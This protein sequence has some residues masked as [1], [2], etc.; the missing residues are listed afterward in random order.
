MKNTIETG[1]SVVAFRQK[2][3]RAAD[4]VAQGTDRKAIIDACAETLVAMKTMVNER[5]ITLDAIW[6]HYGTL[7]VRA[8][9]R[10][11]TL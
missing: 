9:S 10:E 3:G 6:K 7:A 1:N 5:D 4:A 8:I 2:A 11:E